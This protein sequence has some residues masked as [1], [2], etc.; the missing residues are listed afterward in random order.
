MAPVRSAC[1]IFILLIS[2]KITYA[3]LSTKYKT[4]VQSSTRGLRYGLFKPTNY[5]PKKSYPL[6]LYLHGAN[7]TI[8]RDIVWYQET[9]QQDNPVFVLTPKCTSANQGWGNTWTESHSPAMLITLRVLDSL[10]GKYNIDKNRLYIY[11]ISM[12]GFGVFSVLAKEQGKFAAGYAICG[13]SSETAATKLVNTPLWIFHGNYDDVVDVKLSRQ[14]Y[15]QIKKDGGKAV[16]YTEYPGVKHNSWENVNREKTLHRWLLQQSKNK[17]TSSPES[18]RNLQ[19]KLQS[20]TRITLAWG[21]SATDKNPD[22]DVWYYKI[23][24][25]NK[26]LIEI[27]GDQVSYTDTA[28]KSGATYKYDAIAVN[29]NFKESKLSAATSVRV[30]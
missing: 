17:T 1:F 23:F 21:D 9:I 10:A 25:D 13:G 28:I 27:D 22:R 19:A 5:D 16:R 4:Y 8:S 2:V 3:Q 18:P 7:D 14:I 15:E 20:S 26:L 6:I 12:G 11:G 24:R 30:P 29:Y